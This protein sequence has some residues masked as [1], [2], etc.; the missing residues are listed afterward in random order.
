[1]V[2]FTLKNIPRELHQ[3]L[4]RK[5]KQ[6][7]RSLNKEILEVLEN[8]I[9]PSLESIQD[10]LARAQRLRKQVARPVTLR[11]IQRFKRQGRL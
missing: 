10:V 3:R 7:R 2:T 11:E 8:S 6:N 1:M 4:K 9:S 5:A